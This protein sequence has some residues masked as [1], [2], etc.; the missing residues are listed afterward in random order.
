MNENK[1]N[2][3]GFMKL[4]RNVFILMAYMILPIFTDGQEYYNDYQKSEKILVFLDDFNNNENN[5]RIGRN[6]PVISSIHDGFFDLKSVR[7]HNTKPTF[8]NGKVD[9]ERDFEIETNI[10]LLQCES[11]FNSFLFFGYGPDLNQGCEFGFSN[12]CFVIANNYVSSLKLLC[13]AEDKDNI[14][15]FSLTKLTVRKKDNN[16]YFWHC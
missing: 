4:L 13:K 2:T 3:E 16:I 14:N 12:H 15:A 5:W 10:K 9:L 8:I 1:K 6:G 7:P 11:N